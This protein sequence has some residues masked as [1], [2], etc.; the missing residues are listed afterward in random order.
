MNQQDVYMNGRK[1]LRV[2]DVIVIFPCT[3]CN[4]LEHF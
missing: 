1:K 4:F 3:D 2:L